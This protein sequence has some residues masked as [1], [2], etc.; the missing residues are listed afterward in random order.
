MR[1]IA[2]RD[3][4][5]SF[6]AI[7]TAENSMGE[8]VSDGTYPEICKEWAQVIYGRGNERRSAAI[9][10]ADQP[11]TFIVLGNS[12]TR[13]VSVG[14]FIRFDGAEWDIQNKAVLGN[15]EIEF[16]AIRRAR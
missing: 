16:T 10:G 12:K 6:H 7:V 8:P 11:A 13:S 3:K 2:T 15:Q 14:S 1:P 4:L 9:E 5:I